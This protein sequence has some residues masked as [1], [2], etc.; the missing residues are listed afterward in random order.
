MKR[1]KQ[2]ILW[3]PV[4]GKNGEVIKKPLHPY[5]QIP[6]DPHDPSIW[7][8]FKTASA[9][10]KISAD[11]QVGFVFT[12][13]DPLFFL[14]IDHCYTDG[15]W[16][17]LA[18]SLCAQF[19]G[20]LVEVSQ[21]GTGLHIIGTYLGAEPLHKCKNQRAGLELYTS[22]RFVALTGLSEIGNSEIVADA[23]L[24]QTIA[25]YFTP[26]VDGTDNLPPEW[27]TEPDAEWRG[28]E[29]DEEL[30]QIMLASSG[31]AA[32]QFGATAT[33]RDLW[34]A[35]EDTLHN[36]YPDSIGEQGRAFDWSQADA[37]LSQHLAFWTGKNC[38]RMD[39]L[40]RQSSL[41]RDKWDDREAYRHSTLTRAASACKNVY[42]SRVAPLDT[43]VPQ[44]SGPAGVLRDGSQFL[45]PHDQLE[46]FKGC[47]YVR[48]DHK[49]FTPGGALLK[50]NQFNV[51]Y[52]GYGFVM[53][54]DNGKVV[55]SAWDAFTLSQAVR[56]P[57]VDTTVFRP[58]LTP[59]SIITEE[60]RKLVNVYVP[61]ETACIDGDVTPFLELLAKLFPVERDK[62]IILN[63]MAAVIQYPGIKFQW[64]PLVQGVQGNG[65][66][67]LISIIERAV[68]VRYTHKPLARDIDNTFNAWLR[69]KLFIG[70][71]EVYAKDKQ[72][73]IDALKQL[74]TDDRIATTPKGVDQEMGDNRANFFLN[75]N[76][77]DA[78]RLKDDDRR[79]CYFATP[80]QT[81]ED[82]STSGMGGLYFPK[83][84]AWA[85][86]AGFAAIHFYLKTYA[87][88]D[89]FNPTTT[90]HR[91]PK[92]SST[93]EAISA[94]LGGVEQEIL[95]AIGEGR[96]GFGGG[97]ISSVALN[98]LLTD[99]RD[100]K[101]IP[102]NK[103]KEILAELGYV[104]H[105]ALRKGRLNQVSPIDAGAK[106][107]IFIKQG[108]IHA[109]LTQPSEVFRLYLEAQGYSLTPSDVG[110]IVK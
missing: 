57:K 36:V 74:I 56:F 23:P 41:M 85:K 103:R 80:Q 17:A 89:E 76:P 82:L 6:H 62:Q 83:L 48:H 106:P 64:A 11:C 97:W 22:K 25:E 65:K 107:K 44:S 68:G 60:S 16:S 52:G 1:F 88:A 91:A 49:V 108:H 27:T 100:N 21:S 110:A 53:G 66:S 4:L 30:I 51:M 40:F 54:A 58:E 101:T 70:V 92:T 13:D 79:V 37:A 8:D 50:Q 61:I 109:N 39:S 3:K 63:Y 43:E 38:E 99:R 81:I 67:F 59:G 102:P 24:Q 98:R 94:S 47:T 72:N 32:A 14:D 71:E 33:I 87:I 90:C 12:A 78:Y 2:Y 77:R 45:T 19:K 96:P 5:A 29:D 55:D 84:Y 9:L 46:L 75:C 69:H 26:S 93:E 73:V 31:S 15:K 28:P 10:A 105:P 35:N 7:L 42:K 95:E 18:T 34:G 86:D 20:C 104:W